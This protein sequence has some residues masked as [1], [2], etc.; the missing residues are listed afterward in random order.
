[1]PSK[2]VVLDTRSKRRKF[3]KEHKSSLIGDNHLLSITV[4][5]D[6]KKTA[7]QKRLLRKLKKKK[8]ANK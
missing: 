3:K 5:V 8:E 7:I 6:E 1:M 4:A 2:N